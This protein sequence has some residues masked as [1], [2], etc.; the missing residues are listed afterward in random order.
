MKKKDLLNA[1]RCCAPRLVSEIGTGKA[2]YAM[3][4]LAYRGIG[5]KAEA[6]SKWR[7]AVQNIAGN[8]VVPYHHPIHASQWQPWHATNFVRL[9]R[10]VAMIAAGKLPDW[11]WPTELLYPTQDAIV[12]LEVML[13]AGEPVGVDIENKFDGTITAI[14]IANQHV[15]VCLPWER[16]STSKQGPVRGIED[17]DLGPRA[18]ALVRSILES[19]HVPKVLQNGTHDKLFL[20][21][22]GIELRGFVRDTL[23]MSVVANHRLPHDLGYIAAMEYPLNP[24]KAEFHESS[25]SKSFDDMIDLPEEDLRRYCARDSFATIM[26]DAPLLDDVR[27][28]HKG[29][30]R[31]EDLHTKSIIGMHMRDWGIKIDHEAAYNHRITAEFQR[32][33]AAAVAGS[34]VENEGYYAYICLTPGYKKKL[35]KRDGEPSPSQAK[36]LAPFNPG[37]DQQVERVLYGL[38]KLPPTHYTEGGTP[39]TNDKALTE[40]IEWKGQPAAFA[41]AILEYRKWD[42]IIT[43]YLDNVP[44]R[45]YLHP[46]WKPHGTL[47]GRW[48]AGMESSSGRGFSIQTIPRNLRNLFVPENGCVLL[49]ADYSQLELRIIALFAGDIPLIEAYATGAD[50]HRL[51]AAILFEKPPAEVTKKERNLAKTLVY[52]M[53]YGADPKNIWERL[54][55]DGLM[56][57]VEFVQTV[58]KRW[59]QAHPAL[60]RWQD[61]MLE[62][63]RR[64]MYLELPLSGWRIQY[65]G[66]PKELLVTDTSNHPIQGTG[67]NIMDPAFVA[68]SREVGFAKN[69][70]ILAHV[71]DEIVLNTDT[72][73]Q[74]ALILE[75]YMHQVH[76]INGHKMEFPIEFKVGTNWRDC[77]DAAIQDLLERYGK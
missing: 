65:F 49:C 52:A 29:D 18:Q 60:K 46:V 50:V 64:Q 24:W 9:L 31:L 59:Y 58:H 54:R 76:E 70:R 56:V 53:N 57:S 2:V 21:R 62:Q 55:A 13:S 10:R 22:R 45:E 37:S 27:R 16:Y 66:D 38:F 77:K 48:S 61:K 69:R 40:V 74:D 17:Y 63:G 73:Y 19:E 4:E 1:V 43:T 34:I 20:S 41:R 44:K 33:W 51:N 39:S 67:A 28:T 23:L 25:I 71:H 6:F 11:K 30:W 68:V 47:T 8:T 42:K 7:G 12:A 75:K 26:L 14:G 32:G 72:P 15:A 3:G 35:R 36:I 5:G